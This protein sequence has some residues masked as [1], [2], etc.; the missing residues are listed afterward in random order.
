[1][2]RMVHRHDP[3]S[4]VRSSGACGC[5]VRQG[6]GLPCTWEDGRS[7]ARTRGEPGSQTKRV[8]P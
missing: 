4:R 1:M 6:A 5:A 2:V 3:S 7:L 8:V